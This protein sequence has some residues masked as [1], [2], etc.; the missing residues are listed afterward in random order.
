MKSNPISL[1][2]RNVILDAVWRGL[3][4][5]GRSDLSQAEIAAL[6]GVS[7]QTV[8]YAFGNRAGL[9]TAALRRRDETM[10]HLRRFEEIRARRPVSAAVIRSYAENWLDYL[11][12][13]YPVA[14]LL[15]AAALNDADAKAAIED[16]LV[17][18]LLRGLA[19]L[20]LAL[21]E[22][23][24]LP[25]GRSPVAAAEEFWAATHVDAW[26]LL[27]AERGWT[28]EEFRESRLALIPLI[29]GGDA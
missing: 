23:R 17:G 21:A 15:S 1:E 11:P 12:H 6:A 26:R 3:A 24:P 10:P 29:F 14:S 7:R 25:G 8:F 2:T 22:R 5:T 20:A 13:V 9:L 4:E 19:E 27:V 28:A 16:R 18:A